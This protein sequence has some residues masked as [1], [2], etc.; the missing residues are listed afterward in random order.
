MS[1]PEKESRNKSARELR[2]TTIK[3]ELVE[4]TGDA[5]DA[6]VLNYFVVCQSKSRAIEKYIEE[7]R[8]RMSTVGDVLNLAA[9]QGWFYKKA[10]EASEETMLHLS[11]SNMRARIAKLVKRGW[12]QERKN[13]HIKWD[14]TRQYRADIARIDNDL[15]TLGFALDGWLVNRISEIELRIS[16]SENRM[17]DSETRNTQNE[18]AIPS[19]YNKPL[20]QVGTKQQQQIVAAVDGS[21]EPESASGLRFSAIVDDLI[22]AGIAPESVAARL[23]SANPECAAAWFQYWRVNTNLGAGFLRKQIESGELPPESTNGTA[24]APTA[25]KAKP[26]TPAQVEARERAADAVFAAQSPAYQNAI[27]ADALGRVKYIEM[28][29]TNEFVAALKTAK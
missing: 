15:R 19:R 11:P 16:K 17:S 8:A 7:E 1:E 29:H 25:P 28:F 9:T 21:K 13:P 4:L 5:I 6:A 20:K 10:S 3:E 26:M 12:V 18:T 22:S 2:R 23:A 27:D 24:A 14:K